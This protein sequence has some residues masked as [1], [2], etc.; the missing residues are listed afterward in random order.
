[1]FYLFLRKY[2]FKKR[3]KEIIENIVKYL[4]SGENDKISQEDIYKKIAQSY[5]ISYNKFLKK[6]LPQMNKLRRN[7]NRLKLS[8]MQINEKIYIFWELSQ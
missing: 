8:S 1:M 5:G 4:E 6:Y 7:D 2:L 3:C